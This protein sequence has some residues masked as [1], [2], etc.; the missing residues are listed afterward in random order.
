MKKIIILFIFLSAASITGLSGSNYRSIEFNLS[1]FVEDE[2][3][4]NLSGYYVAVYEKTPAENILLGNTKTDEN[5]YYQIIYKSTGKNP[6]I[7]K[8]FDKKNKEVYKSDAIKPVAD[9]SFN[10][11]VE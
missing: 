1:G 3:G 2:M 5:G 9:Q 11:I 10:I 8:V 7:I 6:L 4:I